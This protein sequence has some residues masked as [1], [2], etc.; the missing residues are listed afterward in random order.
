MA[1][2]FI[3]SLKSDGEPNVITCLRQ[4]ASYFRHTATYFKT[5]L[6]MDTKIRD[7][8]SQTCGRM[9]R[10]S[11]VYLTAYLS[12]SREFY[13]SA[14]LIRQILLRRFTECSISA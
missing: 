12:V 13:E 7:R 14:T 1:L 11:A 8:T 10:Y 9:L 4:T 3:F 2:C 5:Y 6:E